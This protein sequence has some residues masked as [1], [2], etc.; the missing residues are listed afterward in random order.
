MHPISDG[1]LAAQKAA[2]VADD[3]QNP[4]GGIALNA[5]Q[6]IAWLRLIRSENV[7]PATFRDLI[8]QY[9][10]AQAAIEAIPDLARRG[11]AARRLKI[12]PR[13]TAEQELESITRLGGRLVAMGE[14]EYPPWL[15][16]A[17]APPPVLTVNGDAAVLTKP[18]VA[19][20]GS[21]NASVA[22]RK[23]AATLARELG[24]HE[25]AIVSG[26]ARGIDAAAHSAAAD[27]GTA[28]IFAGGI[29]HVYPRENASLLDQIM[30]CGGCALTEMPFG[31]MPRPKDFPRRNRIIAGMA[32]ATI[33]VEAAE[34][35]GSLITA[36]LALAENREVMAVPGSPL[37]PRAAGSNGLIKA[38]AKLV[39]DVEDVMESVRPILNIPLPKVKDLKMPKPPSPTLAQPNTQARQLVLQALGPTPTDVDDIIRATGLEIRIV[40]V[41]LLEL[42]LAGRL[43]R[44]PGN[45][46]SHI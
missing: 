22:G 41:I 21:R 33:V 18:F 13:E 25:L 43:E 44:H 23:I 4:G 3:R 16:N 15:R 5:E 30:D 35:S 10:S 39:T 26:L 11:G 1:C 14:P 46:V 28:A 12:T 9:G 8:N 6:R 32:V 40:T 37:D 7:G 2:S 17:H 29:G 31:W 45:R 19:I 20:V 24:A 34:R 42:D 36:R 27:T 38:G